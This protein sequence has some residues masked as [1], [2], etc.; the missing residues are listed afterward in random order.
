MRTVFLSVAVSAFLL[1]GCGGA[2]KVASLEAENQQLT[3]KLAEFEPPAPDKQE[4][5]YKIAAISADAP[6]SPN[7]RSVEHARRLLK[8]VSE[9]YRTPEA[10]IAGMLVYAVNEVKKA[11]GHTPALDVL[12]G[13]SIFGAVDE[14]QWDKSANAFAAF[15]ANYV[16]QRTNVGSSHE[17]ATRSL[18]ALQSAAINLG[19]RKLPG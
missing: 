3:T 9:Q 1:A 7:D 14:R 6:I 10:K 11:G 17:V 18:I 5:A 16:M 4:L 15:C 19:A 13:A 12:E 8:I 2:E